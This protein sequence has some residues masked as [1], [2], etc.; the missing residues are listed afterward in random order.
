MKI[1]TFK[2]LTTIVIFSGFLG[3]SVFIIDKNLAVLTPWEHSYDFV[4]DN[5]LISRLYPNE[6]LVL[7]QKDETGRNYQAV[8]GYPVH[9]E[10]KVKNNFTRGRVSIEYKNKSGQPIELGKLENPSTGEYDWRVLSDPRSMLNKRL[11]SVKKDQQK[12]TDI[13]IRLR[14]SFEFYFWADK[15][16]LD[17]EIEHFDINRHAGADPVELE[18]FDRETQI[19]HEIIKDDGVAE[20]NGQLNFLSNFGVQEFLGQKGW[21]KLSWKAGEDVVTNSIKINS[22]VVLFS[23]KIF[24]TEDLSIHYP[25]LKKKEYSEFWVQADYLS[26]FTPHRESKQ[27]ILLNSQEFQLNEI[28]KYKTADLR[29]YSKPVKVYSKIGDL[30]MRTNGFISFKP[31]DH[32]SF[33]DKKENAQVNNEN[34][35]DW[36]TKSL[37]FLLSPKN[38]Y[39]YGDFDRF[40][41]SFWVP[42][43]RLDEQK[44]KI[45]R[46]KIEF[47]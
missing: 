4:R 37:E 6:S 20:G 10:V 11:P 22:P 31:F 25:Q 18:I 40:I 36:Q 32:F 24:L 33:Q 23:D 1:K 5:R 38:Y 27:T 30:K 3:L 41:F 8:R 47:E 9:F 2:W 7:P 39:S 16:L 45:N 29:D 28:L 44:F 19:Y 12:S 17:L 35:D 43:A 34:S 26:F 46:I 42:F 21:Y 14:G 13:N 15:D